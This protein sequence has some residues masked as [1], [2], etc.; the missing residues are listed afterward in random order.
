VVKLIV[1]LERV[2][3]CC[4]SRATV[5]GTAKK[6]YALSPRGVVGLEGAVAPL[7]LGMAW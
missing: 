7:C 6:M 1:G 4:C 2:G 5:E 3:R